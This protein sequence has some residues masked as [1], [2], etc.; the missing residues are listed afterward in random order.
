MPENLKLSLS[1]RMTLRD[2]HVRNMMWKR[3]APRSDYDEEG[4]AWSLARLVVM[5]CDGDNAPSP[6]LYVGLGL[7]DVWGVLQMHLHRVARRPTSI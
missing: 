5:V 6:R 1:T 2:P 7:A 3:Q 4:Y